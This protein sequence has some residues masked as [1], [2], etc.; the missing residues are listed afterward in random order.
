MYC[1]GDG[2]DYCTV[3][4]MVVIIV[5][6]SVKNF[7]IFCRKACTGGSSGRE[8]EGVGLLLLVCRD[9]GFE[10]RRGN[11]CL[12]VVIVVCCKVEVFR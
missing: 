8:F 12:S 7:G 11:G 2:G 5:Q 3:V 4:V 9:R 10:S 1:C 6:L